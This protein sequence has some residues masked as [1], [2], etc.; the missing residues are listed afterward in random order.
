MERLDVV[1]AFAFDAHF[2]VFRYGPL[3]RRAFSVVP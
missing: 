3:R 2:R 1:D